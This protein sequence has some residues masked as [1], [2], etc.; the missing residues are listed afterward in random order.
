MTRNDNTQPAPRSE[1]REINGLFC[2]EVLR[3]WLQNLEE[4]VRKRDESRFQSKA[5]DARQ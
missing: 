2:E 5:G 3:E 1:E 4:Q